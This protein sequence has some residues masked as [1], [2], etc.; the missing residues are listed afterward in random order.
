MKNVSKFDS[1]YLIYRYIILS[2]CSL[3]QVLVVEKRVHYFVSWL[4]VAK[5][6]FWD[7]DSSVWRYHRLFAYREKIPRYV[8]L[9]NN[10][11]TTLD[12]VM[13]FSDSS[14]APSL[15]STH[16]T[17]SHHCAIF[18]M[19]RLYLRRRKGAL[20]D[21]VYGCDQSKPGPSKSGPSESGPSELLV[22]PVI[23]VKTVNGSSRN[24]HQTYTFTFTWSS[25]CWELSAACCMLLLFSVS[26]FYLPP[27]LYLSVVPWDWVIWLITVVGL[28]VNYCCILSAFCLLNSCV[29][30]KSW[31]PFTSRFLYTTAH[32][33]QQF[34]FGT[35]KLEIQSTV[36]PDRQ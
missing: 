10:G 4:N 11:L 7:A 1:W 27:L 24:L 12:L 31:F 36:E 30:N 8:T 14:L 17:A 9:L 32:A 25:P 33:S 5:R 23:C 6:L 18:A 21:Y 34:I 20:R 16:C 29:I 26:L 3:H 15:S 28:F 13:T 35:E 22:T 2:W 19:K